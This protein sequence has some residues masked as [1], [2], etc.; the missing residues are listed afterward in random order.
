MTPTVPHILMTASGALPGGETW[1]C[2]LRTY[3]APTYLSIASGN[4]LALAVA[5]RWRVFQNTQTLLFGQGALEKATLTGLIVREINDVGVTVTQY[6]AAP[7][8]AVLNADFR[9]L[10]PNQCALAVSLLTAR[11]GRTGKG[12]IYLPCIALNVGAL[13]NGQI[14]ASVV[15]SIAAGVKILLDGINTDLA[16]NFG[17]TLRLAVQSPKAAKDWFDDNS[18]ADYNGAE[19][20]GFK[21]GSVIDTQRRRRDSVPETYVSGVLA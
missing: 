8:T 13:V 14:L 2:G 12:R 21:V 19:M 10:L 15:N 17:S 7:T 11:A 4:A 18:L 5:N 16:T 3:R 9:A 20:I 6:E 1:S